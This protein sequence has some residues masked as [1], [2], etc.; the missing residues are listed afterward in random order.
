MLALVGRLFDALAEPWVEPGFK[1]DVPE[2]SGWRH[3][4]WRGL[5]AAMVS[6]ALHAVAL[7]LLAQFMLPGV[8]HVLPILH[9]ATV[10][11]EPPPPPPELNYVLAAPS[12]ESRPTLLS[13]MALSTAPDVANDA[14]ILS[15]VRPTDPLAEARVLEPLEDLK[16]F[17]LDERIA[18]SGS[19]GEEVLHVEGAVDRLTYEIMTRLEEN[20]VLVVWLMDASLSLRAERSEVARRLE[21]VY[22][23]LQ[24]LGGTR[25][26]DLHSAVVSFGQEHRQLVRPTG[27]HASVVQAI[28]SVADDESGVENVFSAVMACVDAFKHQ[29]VTERRQLMFII[30]TDESGDDYAHLEE[31]V[32]ACRRSNIPVFVVGPSAMFSKELGTMPF[33]HVDGKTYWLP[34]CRGPDSIRQE[35]VEMPYWFD[36]PQYDSLHSGLG[37]FALTRLAAATGGAYF[38][39]DHARDQVPFSL[40]TMRRY[41]PEYDSIPEYIHKVQKSPL[42]RAVLTA[43]EL[44]RQRKLRGTPRLE[45]APTAQTYAQ[46]L[47][48]AQQTAAYNLFTLQQALEAFGPKG[49]EA[50]RE[51]E[52]SAR[53]R[54]WYDLTYGRLLAM[55]VRCNEYNWACAEMKGRGA[56]FVEKKSNRWRFVPNPT[57]HCGSQFV[58]QANEA[59]RLLKRCIEENPGTPWALLAQ[60][61]LEHPFGFV[62]EEAYVPPPPAPKQRPGNNAPPPP[63]SNEVRQE[64]PRM[65]PKPP[66]LPKL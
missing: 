30:W 40:Q 42:R 9:L 50:H 43:V 32:D 1:P 57:V 41:Q 62:V 49:L 8:Q 52:P 23:E 11:R 39:K 19:V 2:P 45:F 13:A 38:I 10:E 21:K 46:E 33:E 63:P 53:W 44:T 17:E 26:D 20:R 28:R 6:G 18:H 54:A 27:E 16:G 59:V 25:G 58:K 56:D 51:R 61:E 37:P 35:L 36:G 15:V 7:A 14:E 31:A 29:R 22:H 64:Q 65:L 24:E 3:A 60:R 12:E 34:V 66:P 4:W 47:Q 5:Q 48:E 55:N